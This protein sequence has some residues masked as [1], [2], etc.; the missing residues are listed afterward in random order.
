[1]PQFDFARVALPQIIWLFFSFG[2]LFLLMRAMLPKVAGVAERR[3]ST[4]GGDLDAADKARLDAETRREA[5]EAGIAKTRTDAQGLIES[6]KADAAKANEAKMKAADEAAAA[7]I[8][9][10]EAELSKQ[11]DAALV[12]LDAIAV[13]ATQ[14]VVERLTGT[15]PAMA[16]AAAAVAQAGS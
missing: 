12:K 3:A 6:A 1:M 14:D 5:Y 4:I 13:D 7:K 10:A 16:A 15:R 2:L 9:A 8:A 11:R